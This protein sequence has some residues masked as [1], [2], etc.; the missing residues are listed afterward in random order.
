MEIVTALNNGVFKITLNRPKAYNSFNTNLAKLLQTELDNADKNNAVKVVIIT[1]EGNAFSTGQDI[2]EL[3]D[4]NGPELSTILSENFNPIIR[5]IRNTSKPVIAAVNGVAAGAG[6]NI[7]LACDLVVASKSAQFIQIF[8]KI[9]LMPDAAG[10]FY[11]PRLIGRQKAMAAAML[12]EPISSTEAEKIGMIYKCIDDLQFNDEV[13]NL[14][15][16]LSKQPTK[17]LS[18]IKKAFNLSESNTFEQQLKV[19]EDFQYE[20][21][22]TNNFKNSIQAFVKK[23]K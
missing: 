11:L 9:G 14:A 16:K 3:L 20:L 1:G 21:S 10:T 7:A 4:T 15:T 19:E 5:K 22:L 8:S 2:K 6:A 13:N 17:A 12:A 23:Q 18:L